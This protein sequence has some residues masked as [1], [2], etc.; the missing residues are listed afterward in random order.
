MF[1]GS[2]TTATILIILV[3]ISVLGWGFNRARSYGKLGII[4]WLQSV[5]LTVPW[6]LFFGLFTAG[7]YLNIVGILFLVVASAGLYIF[8]GKRL[9]A[10]GQDAVLQEPAARVLNDQQESSEGKKPDEQAPATAE[11]LTASPNGTNPATTEVVP[12]PDEDLKSI[13]GIFGIDTF[14]ATETIPYQEGVIFK[15]NMR[16]GTPEEV[17][18]RLSKSLEERLSDRYRLF[19]VESPEGRPVVII[20]PSSNDPQPSTLPQKILAVVLLIATI[21]TSLEASGLLLNFDFFNN[22]ERF[23]EVL[24]LSTG[25]WTIFAA[26]ELGHWWQAK[27]HKVR[28]SLPFFIPSWQIGSFGA[29]TRFESLIPH[30]TS[31]FDIAIAGPAAGG[32][33]SLLMLIAGLLLSHEGSAFQIPTQFFQGSVLVGTLA[34][35]FLGASLE[36]TIVDVHPLTI[37]GW[38]GLVVTA[39]NL[40][41]AGQLDGGRI[42]QAI[43]GRQTAR[44][45]TI[46]TLVVLGIIAL[47]NPANPL[48]LY[49]AI[50]ILFLQRGL[51]RPSLNEITEPD[52]TRAILGLLAL[53]LMIVTLI[54]LTPALAIRLGIGG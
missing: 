10:A 42:V 4:A 45:T 44:R 24:P 29:I 7:I 35:V 20:L 22:P 28:L 33:V 3:A 16:G 50:V 6:L 41:P 52:D 34:R 51:E 21:A 37:V 26:H 12:I 30:R 31:L 39:L 43:Y 47:V 14:F 54:P 2:E 17:Y 46:A 8:L 19:L 40:M 49:W 25:V 23:R 32:I 36:G 53:F 9:R 13:Q 48:V 11:N 18:A 27:R 15:G 1:T 5:V 38:L